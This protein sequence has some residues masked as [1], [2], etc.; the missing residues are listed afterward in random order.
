MFEMYELK[1]WR[2][3]SWAC[4]ICGTGNGSSNQLVP[5]RAMVFTKAWTGFPALC[6]ARDRC[7]F[8][9][10]RQGISSSEGDMRMH[11]SIGDSPND[12]ELI[13]T[14]AVFLYRSSRRRMEQL[15]S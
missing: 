2:Q 13:A 12:D 8:L 7:F 1:P 5:P 10:T 6:P 11:A 15:A 4:T 14:I 3:R 9:F